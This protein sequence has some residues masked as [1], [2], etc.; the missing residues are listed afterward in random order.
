MVP[1]A[2]AFFKFC[3]PLDGVVIGFRAAAGEDNFAWA[4]RADEF[5]Y[6]FA[7]GINGVA[8]LAA[9]GVNAGAVAERLGEIGHHRIPHFGT[10]RRGGVVI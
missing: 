1:L 9:V 5:G 4:F 8:R 3:Q 2:A 7:S 6:L 10:E